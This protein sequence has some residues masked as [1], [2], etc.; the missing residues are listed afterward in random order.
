MGYLAPARGRPNLTLRANTLA[1]RVVIEGGRVTGI[2]VA[3]E[4]R[5]EVIPCHRLVLSA[6]AILTPALLVRSG[7]G[8][9]EALER[10]GVTVIRDLPGVGARL[11]DHPACLVALA[12]KEGVASFDHPIIQTALRYTARGS[13]A[14]N[15]ML[16]QPLSFIDLGP[17]GPLLVAIAAVVQRSFSSGRLSFESLD[18]LAAPAI[19][20]NLL[21]DERDL[22]RLCEGMELAAKVA[23]MPEITALT[24]GIVWPAL[25]VLESADKLRPWIKQGCGSGLHPSG[26][27]PMGP[28]DAPGTVVDAFGRVLGVSGLFIADAGIMPT[29]PRANTNLPTIMI[30]ERFGAWF[31]ERQL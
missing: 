13:A 27:T 17:D 10:L 1:R 19:E 25:D 28:P 4:G 11:C 21:G 18:P 14:R 3:T 29:I 2:E 31:R 24:E 22:S 23:A 20:T 26:T 5:V 8:P 15:D 6:G 12:P 30:G 7:V 16:L 9:R